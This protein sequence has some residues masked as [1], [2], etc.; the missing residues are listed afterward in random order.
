LT[1]YEP[2][3]GVPKNNGKSCGM[4]LAMRKQAS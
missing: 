4:S 3:S 1:K 2:Q